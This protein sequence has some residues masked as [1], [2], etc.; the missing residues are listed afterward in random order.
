VSGR[1]EIG[2]LD[3]SVASRLSVGGK[4]GP[5]GLPAAATD[6][7]DGSVGRVFVSLAHQQ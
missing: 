3:F 7:F 4:L 6:Q 2:A 1:G 5:D